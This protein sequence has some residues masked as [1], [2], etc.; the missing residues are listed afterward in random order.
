[1]ASLFEGTPQTATSY[2][3]TT[4][5]SPKWMQDA[6]YNQIQLAQ[7]LAYKPY[8]AYSLPEVAELSPLQQQAY[9]SVQAQQGQYA[10]SLTAAQTGMQGLAGADTSTALGTTQGSYLNPAAAS[11]MLSS[12]QTSLGTAA[13]QNIVGAA[14]PYLSAAGQYNAVNAAAPAL[15]GAAQAAENIYGTASPYLSQAAGMQGSTAASPYLSAAGQ[16]DVTS[17]ASPYLS[18]AGSATGQAISGSALNT[19]SPYLSAAGQSSVSNI[20][21]YMNP[22]QQNVMDV[23]AQ[24][25]ARNLSENVLPSVSDAFIKA[26]QFGSSGMGEFGSR[27]VRDTQEA[28]LQ[29]QAAAAQAGYTQAAQLQQADLARQAQLAQTAGGLSEADLARTLQAGTQYGTLGQTTG[30]LTAQQQ[31]NLAAIGQ[32]QLAG[33]QAQQ[34][35]GL[36]AAQAMQAAQ[37]QDYATQMSALQQQAALATQQQQMGYTDTAAL[38]A[39]GQMQRAVTQQQLDAA[40]AQYEAAQ[41]YP[42]QQLAYAGEQIRGLSSSVPQT[43]GVSNTSVGGEYSAS[44]LSQLAGGFSALSGLSSLLT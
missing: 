30:Q 13:G 32:A 28:V 24:Q 35:Y 23:I 19:A 31:Q 4:T 17:A 39:A 26:G 37:S 36:N 38:E 7:N 43:T 29:Q 20:Q 34:G 10:P 9:S 8:E 12:G 25:G 14:S 1:M 40:K 5:D 42:Q 16:Y 44:P 21:D 3:E 6:I 22:Y 18:A 2:V 15:G 27:A 41:L 33:G 11:S